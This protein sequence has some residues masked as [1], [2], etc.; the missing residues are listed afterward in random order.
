MLEHHAAYGL[1]VESLDVVIVDDSK[2]VLTMIRSM[3]SA[4]KVERVRAYDRADL[5]LQAIMHEPPNVI[6][7]DLAMS[8]MSGTQLLRL[9]RQQT[10][11]PLCYIPVVVITAH[12]TE[13][14]VA[15][16][17]ECGA[18]HVLAKP[19]SAAVLQSRLRSLVTDPRM[20]RLDGDRYVIDGMQEMLEEKKSRMESLAK[21]RQFHTEVL[22]QAVESQRTVDRILKGQIDH[23]KEEVRTI[24]RMS[25]GMMIGEKLRKQRE[26]REER[27]MAERA[28]QRSGQRSRRY[29][30][31]SRRKAG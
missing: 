24:K 2:T 20:M 29:A 12:A 11:A 5:A 30:G 3:I 27:E 1:D 4:L 17:F 25:T 15:Q 26:E 8:P 14:R 13:R 16:L 7:T 6:L 10:M 9:I 18:H 28:A 23:N 22:P 19:M 21:A 31:V